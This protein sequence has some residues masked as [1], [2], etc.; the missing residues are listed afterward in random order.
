MEHI[1]F[2]FIFIGYVAS[3]MFLFSKLLAFLERSTNEKRKGLV[4]T[5]FILFYFPL[6][7]FRELY[8][9]TNKNK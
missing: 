8:K 2:L 6:I 1:A 7:S 5:L 9:P 4:A 3:C